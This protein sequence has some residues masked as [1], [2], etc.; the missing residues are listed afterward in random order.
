MDKS[1]VERTMSELRMGEVDKEGKYRGRSIEE[2]R[3]I[4]WMED[5]NREGTLS[6]ERVVDKRKSTMEEKRRL[7]IVERNDR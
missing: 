3:M 5:S 1:F 7:Q 2:E 4:E 6:G